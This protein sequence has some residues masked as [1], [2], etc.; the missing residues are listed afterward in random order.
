MLKKQEKTSSWGDGTERSPDSSEG[1]DRDRLEEGRQG[2]Q[3][4]SPRNLSRGANLDEEMEENT[5]IKRDTEFR[6]AT[7]HPLDAD[8]GGP[9][10]TPDNDLFGKEGE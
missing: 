9:K 7:A 2:G 3:S 5:A 6:D 10:V 8:A 1:I 4:R